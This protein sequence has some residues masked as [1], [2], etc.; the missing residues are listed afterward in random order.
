[1]ADTDLI[2][3]FE[4]TTEET[5]LIII[6]PPCTDYKLVPGQSLQL[7]IVD[8]KSH[9]ADVSNIIDVRYASPHAINIDVN[10]SFKLIV[11]TN[12]EEEVIWGF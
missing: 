4:N 2:L 10:Y 11:M 8:Y 6:D 9:R 5:L 3:K 1:M 7:K 12:N